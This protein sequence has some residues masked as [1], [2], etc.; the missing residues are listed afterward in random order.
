MKKT[1]Q[2]PFA[3]ATLIV[4]CGGASLVEKT[5]DAIRSLSFWF[6]K[7]SCFKLSFKVS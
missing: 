3:S 7:A 1:G 2:P 6:C 5:K 4:S